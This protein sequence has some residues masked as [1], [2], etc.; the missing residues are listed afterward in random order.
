VDPPVERAARSGEIR[1]L[2]K[3]GQIE[4]A[5]QVLGSMRERYPA[6]PEVLQALRQVGDDILPLVPLAS[7]DQGLLPEDLIDRFPKPPRSV[8]HTKEPAI[9]QPTYLCTRSGVLCG[10]REATPGRRSW[11]PVMRRTNPRRAFTQC[12]ILRGRGW[13]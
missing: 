4:T 11:M 12:Q 6:S 13:R 5:N 10:C 8:N 1:T 2:L 7:L 9:A 3:T